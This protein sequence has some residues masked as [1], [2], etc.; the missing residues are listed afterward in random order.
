MHLINW[1]ASR[2]GAA[3][4]VKGTDKATGQEAKIVGVVS[5]HPTADAGASGYI[6][7]KDKAGDMHQ[8]ALG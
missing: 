7:A 1:K 6:W 3:M 8:L 4:T 5:I 2:A